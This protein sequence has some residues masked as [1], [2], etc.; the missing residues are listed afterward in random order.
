MLNVV[1]NNWCVVSNTALLI[2][3]EFH[4]VLKIGIIVGIFVKLILCLLETKTKP[5]LTKL[6]QLLRHLL[7]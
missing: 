4:C 7:T 3:L 6:S 5:S 2:L 1:L